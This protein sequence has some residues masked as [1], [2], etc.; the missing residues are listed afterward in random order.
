[1]SYRVSNRNK[2]FINHFENGIAAK[3]TLS[4]RRRILFFKKNCQ[5]IELLISSWILKLEMYK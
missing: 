3:T 5:K 2:F 1:M 4:E